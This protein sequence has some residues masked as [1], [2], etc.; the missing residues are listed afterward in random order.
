MLSI[1]LHNLKFFAFHGLYEEEKNNG[2][3]FE[4]DAE[5]EIDTDKKIISIEQTIDYV[6]LHEIICK[7]MQQ[8][9]PLLET[10]AQ[11][12]A[13]MIHEADNRIAHISIRIK[14][15]SPPIKNCTGSVGVTFTKSF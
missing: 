6:I 13:E 9:T 14:K 4:V 2:N 15:I 10:L 12:L 8:A 5:V 3:N 11:D 1:H 7:R